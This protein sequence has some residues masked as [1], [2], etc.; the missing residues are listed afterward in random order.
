MLDGE[1]VNV[2]SKIRFESPTAIAY[3]LCGTGGEIY[4]RI[5]RKT[6]GRL[7]HEIKLNADTARMLLL[8]VSSLEIYGLV[9]LN[10]DVAKGLKIE[11]APDTLQREGKYVVDKVAAPRRQKARGTSQ[12]RPKVPSG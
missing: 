12:R 2:T 1:T 3:T 11:V 9:D 7:V 5:E 8:A 6:R 4:I 10:L